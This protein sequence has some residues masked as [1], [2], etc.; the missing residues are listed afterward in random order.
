M[1]KKSIQALICFSLY[2]G[3]HAQKLSAAVPN[4]DLIDSVT[5]VTLPRA[6]YDIALTAYANGSLQMKAILALHDN[7][8][9]G[10]SFD[11]E[12][13]IGN[14]D[15]Q[16]HIPGVVA[17]FK[18]TDGWQSFPLLVA[19]GYDSFYLGD[20]GKVENSPNLLARIIYGPYMVLS[21]PI[22]LFG[23]EQ[24]IHLGARMP[25][26]PDY[27]PQD[28]ALY[29]GFDFP[30]GFFVPMFEINRVYFATGRLEEVLFNLGF[31]LNIVE[32][33]SLELNFLFGLQENIGRVIVL[34]YV[35]FF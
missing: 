14:G 23:G 11:T 2:F 34:E 4:L 31:K 21:K 22:F 8:Y 16:V 30:I 6:S 19:F 32:N 35:N 1:L 27:S 7:I 33:F 20:H 13:I 26:Q 9:L 29:L 3:F 15:V 10:A 12:N 17:K 18:L 28:T 24:H 5:A 25:V